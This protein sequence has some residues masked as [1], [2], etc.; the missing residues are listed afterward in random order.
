MPKDYPLVA[1]QVGVAEHVV[2]EA[3]LGEDVRREVRVVV[4]PVVR[5]LLRG[6]H[7]HGLVAQLVV[8]DDRQRGER[9]P[10]ADA[11][12]EDA[13][14]VGLQLVDDAGGGVALEVVE[15]LPDRGV[16]VAGQVVG[17]DVLA[18]VVEELG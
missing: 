5:E 12:G 16:L 18:D 10:E 2:V 3:V 13:A 9:L 8:L 15:L 14:V 4:R 1:E 17:Q 6:K 7:E 11:V